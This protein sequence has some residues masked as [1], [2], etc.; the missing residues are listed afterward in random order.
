MLYNILAKVL[1][2][3]LKIILPGCISENQLAFVHGRSITD[4]VPITFKILH[5]MKIKHKG[6]EGELA[7]K[8]DVSKTYDKIGL[9]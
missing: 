3:R 1:T 5:H 9:T 6:K 7:L 8:L 4:N 2:N